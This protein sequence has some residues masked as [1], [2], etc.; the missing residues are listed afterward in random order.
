MARYDDAAN[1]ALAK[2]LQKAGA[3]EVYGIVG[4]KTHAKMILV[5][6]RENGKL[7]RY[8]HLG[9][10]NYHQSTAQLY[11]DYGMFTSNPAITLDLHEIFLQLTSVTKIPKLICV[12]KSPF[13][14]YKTIS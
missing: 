9:T 13:T 1:I 4:M 14:L 12:L 3:H 10:G 8:A 6:R 11:T 7:I 5:I 2:R